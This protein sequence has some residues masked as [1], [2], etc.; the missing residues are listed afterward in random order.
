[1]RTTAGGNVSGNQVP[2]LSLAT[3]GITAPLTYTITSLP[4]N[5]A[6]RN[7]ANALITTVPYVLTAPQVS[8]TPNTGFL[9]LDTF[10]FTVSNGVITSSASGNIRV[11]IPNCT[12]D[13][14]G[15]N[16]GR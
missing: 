15:C 16:N 6:L 14:Q 8:Y 1:V 13:P 3:P 10:S 11:F 5:G 7:S 9:G 4:S 12:S 2:M